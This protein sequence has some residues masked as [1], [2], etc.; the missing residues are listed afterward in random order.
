MLPHNTLT[1]SFFCFVFRQSSTGEGFFYFL[2]EHGDEIVDQI[3]LNTSRSYLQKKPSMDNFCVDTCGTSPEP[4]LLTSIP[5]PP[6]CHLFPRPSV[7]RPSP[8]GAIPFHAYDGD[9]TAGSEPFAH[10]IRG[11]NNYIDVLTPQEEVEKFKK[12]YTIRSRRISRTTNHA[13]RNSRSTTPSIRP[14]SRCSE[15]TSWP[16]TIP[17]SRRTMG[18]T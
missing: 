18:N 15:M 9:P 11:K 16:E 5:R 17:R 8:P 7:V 14:T 3:R 6:G 4:R 2:T 1:S 10:Y 12:R 13:R